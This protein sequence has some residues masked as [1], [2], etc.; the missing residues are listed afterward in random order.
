MLW[1]WA[2]ALW[3]VQS[4]P[5]VKQAVW[6]WRKKIRPKLSNASWPVPL[7]EHL[8]YSN[9]LSLLLIRTSCST[10]VF[11][12]IHILI[13]HLVAGQTVQKY[14][15]KH[16]PF[17]NFLILRGD[18]LLCPLVIL[19]VVMFIIKNNIVIF[20]FLELKYYTPLWCHTLQDKDLTHINY[21]DGIGRLA[22]NLHFSCWC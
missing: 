1:L 8:L 15:W 9:C 2:L 18:L 19:L 22:G 12:K 7:F 6:W 21:L 16:F 20:L 4:L 14:F 3:S 11:G 5:T 10:F 17:T 13:Y